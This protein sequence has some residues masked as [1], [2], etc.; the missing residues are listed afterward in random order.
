MTTDDHDHDHDEDDEEVEF[1]VNIEPDEAAL[2][3]YRIDHAD[4]ENAL[5][6]A[7]EQQGDS[8]QDIEGDQVTS[9]IE[10]IELTINGKPYRLAELANV[11]IEQVEQGDEEDEEG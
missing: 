10:D 6:V 1:E 4:F 3:R 8:L 2:E 9:S 5:Y 11:S 7:L